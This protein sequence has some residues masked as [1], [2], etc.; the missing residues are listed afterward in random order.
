[1]HQA[2]ETIKK[3]AKSASFYENNNIKTT[4]NRNRETKL[5]QNNFMQAGHERRS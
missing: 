5:I 3:A 2:H 1:M 4:F